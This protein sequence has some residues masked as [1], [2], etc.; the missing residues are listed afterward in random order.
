MI[1]KL[2]HLQAFKLQ[3]VDG[4][5]SREESNFLCNQS[6]QPKVFSQMVTQNMS[7]YQGLEPVVEATIY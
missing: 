5:E 1:R 2:I 4:S 7:F 6:P 3:Q